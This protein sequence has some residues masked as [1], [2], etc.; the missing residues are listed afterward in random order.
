[1]TVST[2]IGVAVRYVV[3][4]AVRMA[5]LLSIASLLAFSQEFEVASIKQSAQDAQAQTSGGL[6]VDGSMVRYSALALKLYLGMAWRLKNYQIVAPDWMTSTRWDI[7]AK[8]PQGS[9]SKQIPEMMQALLLDRFQM[10]MHRETRE[11]PVYGLVIGKGG[12]KLK[13]S[14]ANPAEKGGEPAAQ[15]ANAAMTSGGTTVTYG[16]G[17]YFTIGNNR[18]EGK[19]LSVAVIADALSRFADR[20]VIDMT[21]LEGSYDFSME[22]SPEDFRAMMIRAAIAQGT[23]V[24][25]EAL[26]LLDASSGDTLFNAVEK[27]GLKM[28]SRKAPI[29]ILVIDEAQKTPTEN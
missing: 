23:V 20:P 5:T 22:F 14:P 3:V 18:F 10:K 21:G 26:K 29:E 1:M 15:S 11:I 28:E 6:S 13:D 25:P 16:N 9:N 19:K 27:L 17:A 8:L 12:L 2:G 24:S 4:R 7:T